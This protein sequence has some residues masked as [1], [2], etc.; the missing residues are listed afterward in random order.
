MKKITMG[1]LAHVDA[2]KTTLTESI[3]FNT[4]MIRSAGRVDDGNAF[5]DT[6]EL[7]KK[8][9]VT[10]L[11]KQA[12]IDMSS[13]SE[14]N[15]SGDDV[16]ITIIDTP[17]HTD[18]IGETERALS[19]LDVAVL[20]V[21]GPDGVTAS[22][23]RLYSMLEA[24]KVPFFVFVNKMDMCER[25]LDELMG[26]LNELGEGFVDFSAASGSD[27]A[28]SEITIS[29]MFDD[30]TKEEIASLSEDTI[31][32]FLET[33]EIS[34]DDIK[35]LIYGRKLRP[36]LFGSALKNSGV[37]TFV[38]IFTELIPDISYRDSFAAKVYRLSYEDGHKIAFT[39]I[40]GGEI[41]VR[42]SVK[43]TED[44]EEKISQIRLYSGGKFE[45]IQ[46]AEAGDVV[47]LVGLD[48]AYTG[49]GIGVEIDDRRAMCQPVLRYD[50]IL[51]IDTAPRVFIPKFRELVAENPLLYMEISEK[52]QITISVMGEFQLEILKSMI[53]DRCGVKVSFAPAGIIMKETISSPVIGYGHFEPLRH[54]AEVQILM[55]PLP[56]GTG[57]EIASALSVNELSINWQKTILSTLSNDLP[58]G[59]LTGS[60]L[61]DIRFTLING[62]S[63]LKHTDSQDF[64]ESVRR[65]VRQGLM[66]A[67]NVLLEPVMSLVIQLPAEMVGRAMND[68]TQMGGN[69]T[70]ENQREINGIQMATLVGDAPARLVSDYQTKLTQYTSGRGSIDMR[71]SGY[72]ECPEDTADEMIAA[73]GYDPDNDKNNLSGSVFIEHGA[74]YY[75]PWFESEELM[76]L[77]KR[78]ADFFETDE[79][80]DEERLLA[81]AELVKAAAE[82]KKNESGGSFEERF[83]A[84]GTDEIDD[85][86]RST[87]HANAGSDKKTKRVYL[88]RNRVVADMRKSSGSSGSSQTT[89]DKASGVKTKNKADKEKYLLVDGYNIIHA[90]KSLKGLLT[91]EE[92]GNVT[93]GDKQSID[94]ESARFKLLDIMSEYRV[95]KD[96]EII[97]VFDAYNVRGHFTEKMDYMGVHVVYTK[98]AE[99][100]DQYIARFTLKNAKN[101]DITVATSDGMI[102]L[103]IRGE[104]TR[105]M[106]AGDLERDVTQCR[107][108]ALGMS[109]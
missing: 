23:R 16:R 60:A 109:F 102:Q 58:V 63:H 49:M 4:G 70:T 25:Q 26:E 22:T 78:E 2:G 39:K 8:R 7:E 91:D 46:K 29:E 96:T 106:T 35:A 83:E 61:A 24:Y 33:G 20:L 76:H 72:R 50:I 84:I 51:P 77:P 97:V 99:T 18:F 45:S 34:V 86:L 66:K 55:E 105:L 74:G 27:G 40:T 15:S 31:E 9:G 101:L 90:W 32:R 44:D 3:L 103:I 52:E 59:V 108:S 107:K 10:I 56:R 48:S 88:T 57:I 13:D 89:G 12:V 14:L 11:S 67:E 82:K 54:Y 93:S 28:I 1:I 43:V 6:E 36:V 68:I 87:T 5:L 92:T 53:L 71:L 19:I 100:A 95:L 104:N 85:I 65:A 98:E 42:E 75:V 37:D 41:A 62:K 30:G 81:E 69:L 73:S 17:G 64:R 80:S 79:L 47:A 21:S 38:R 94:L